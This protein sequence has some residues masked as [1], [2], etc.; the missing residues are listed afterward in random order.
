VIQLFLL[1]TW[2]AT[3]KQIMYFTGGIIMNENFE[4][5][6]KKAR[7]DVTILEAK[8]NL[9]MQMYQE[10]KEDEA[11]D[12]LNEAI[13]LAEKMS[14]R[15]R[16]LVLSNGNPNAKEDLEK[17]LAEEHPMKI[18][19]TPQGWFGIRMQPL[20]LNE[21][22]ASKEFIRGIIYPAM[23]NF[24]ADKNTVRYDK[25]VVA[26]RHV[27]DESIEHTGRPDYTNSEIKMV[28]DTVAMYVMVDDSPRHCDLYHCCIPGADPHTEVYVIPEEEF[29][30]WIK[31]EDSLSDEGFPLTD[32]VP[33]RW[34][35]DI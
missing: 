17:I 10:G 28:T 32:Q 19:F 31:L 24:F 25:C 20:A 27:L 18:G 30:E 15:N 34:K 13:L 6:A 16:E 29:V 1:I 5:L 4:T 12:L 35:K 21:E 9:L 11:D 26:Y 3:R 14:I 8:L 2:H 33:N 23:R 7:K 22:I